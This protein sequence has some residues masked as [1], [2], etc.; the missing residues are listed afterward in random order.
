MEKTTM[1]KTNKIIAIF[2]A[3]VMSLTLMAGCGENNGNNGGNSS[4]SA[5]AATAEPV[6]AVGKWT[7]T[8]M[9]HD[10]ERITSEELG[11][12][13]SM[14]IREDGTMTLS[15]LSSYGDMVD[16]ETTWTQDNDKVFI[17]MDGQA[18]EHELDGD[19]LI[20]RNDDSVLIFER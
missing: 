10:G 14:D 13:M 20:E 6:T 16:I 3:A 12:P 17:V 8:V 19:T 5:P 4:A 11:I 9:E 18:V 1:K 7:F 2:A 15:G